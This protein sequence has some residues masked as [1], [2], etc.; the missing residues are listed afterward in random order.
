M[1]S[2][3]NF[4]GS[5]SEYERAAEARRHHFL[6]RM[7]Q[8]LRFKESIYRDHHKQISKFFLN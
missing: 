6:E 2:L 7:E 4:G 5:M 1:T 8:K 3:T